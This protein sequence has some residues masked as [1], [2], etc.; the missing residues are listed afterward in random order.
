MRVPGFLLPI[1]LAAWAVTAALG[2]V[3]DDQVPIHGLTGT[4]AL[5]DNVDK[6]YSGVNTLVVKTSDGIE[7]VV[8]VTKATKVHG[9]ASLGTLTPGTPVVVH[10]TVK[11]IETSAVEIDRLG[12]DGLKQNEGTVT[13]VDRRNK[14]ISIRFANGTTETLRLT[15]YAAD[16]SDRHTR[17]GSRVIVYYVNESGQ[18]VAHYFKPAH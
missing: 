10:Y 18:R 12:P 8:H 16:G 13:N 17:R 5:P 9:A 6:L 15:R 1:V 4:I 2:A 3:G 11:G 14:R 7:H